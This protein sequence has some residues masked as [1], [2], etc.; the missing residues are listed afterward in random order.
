[1]IATTVG[2]VG[3]A[4]IATT[5]GVVGIAM[6]ATTVGV[7]EM[8]AA[9]VGVV[10]IA[11]IAATAG[12]AA[13]EVIGKAH[14]KRHPLKTTLSLS[15][16]MS[17]ATSGPS[18]AHIVEAGVAAATEHRASPISRSIFQAELPPLSPVSSRS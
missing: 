3:I 2:V 5:V 18:G 8:I 11:M 7:V 16:E 4:M 6:I 13:T 14:P 12:V 10:G 17:L 15:C 1:M 9:T